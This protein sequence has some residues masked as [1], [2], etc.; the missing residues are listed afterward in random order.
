MEQPSNTPEVQ[1][2]PKAI[3]PKDTQHQPTPDLTTYSESSSSSSTVAAVVVS[4]ILVL[5]LVG[6]L[7]FMMF[8]TR[9]GPRIRA[10]LTNT[11]YDDMAGARL[12]NNASASKQNVMA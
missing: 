3:D 2:R 1:R 9:L 5:A 10:R 12:N 8:R 4:L 7:A 11:P 6:G